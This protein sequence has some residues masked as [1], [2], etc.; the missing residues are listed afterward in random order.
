MRGEM[1]VIQWRLSEKALQFSALT[2]EARLEHESSTNLPTPGRAAS[3]PPP[4]AASGA[5]PHSVAL[6]AEPGG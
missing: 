2:W 3:A 4:S 5:H 6:V 1:S